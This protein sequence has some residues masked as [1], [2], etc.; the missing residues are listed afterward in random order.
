MGDK[1][2]KIK[3]DCCCG[4]LIELREMRSLQKK[5]PIVQI[6]RRV[7]ASSSTG[8]RES[9][10]ADEREKREPQLRLRVRN[11]S[12]VGCGWERR[13]RG[14]S[15]SCGCEWNSSVVGATERDES[16]ARVGTAATEETETLASLGRLKSGQ[17][18]QGT[19]KL[20]FPSTKLFWARLSQALRTGPGNQTY[21]YCMKRVWS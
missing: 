4:E 21:P 2:E 15:R 9:T 13:E 12:V 20:V 6:V 3:C 5:K 10:V 14:E 8:S 18:D 16:E 7:R 11:P 17:A 1:P 19:N